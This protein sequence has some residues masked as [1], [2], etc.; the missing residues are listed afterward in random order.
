VHQHCPDPADIWWIILVLWRVQFRIHAMKSFRERLVNH[1]RLIGTLLN[2]PLPAIAEICAEAG[3][4]WLFLDMEHGALDLHDVERITQAVDH[5]CPCVV[6][7]PGND[8]AWIGK[9]LDFGV[10]GIIVPQVN[11]AEQAAHAVFAA[12]YPPQGGRGVGVGRASRYGAQLTSYLQTA[13]DETA[14]I[15]QIE[16]RD[17]VENVE[18]IASVAGV[19]ALMIGPLDLSGSFG[20]PAQIDAQEVQAA[21]RRV[22]EFGSQRQIPL[23]LFCPDAERAQRALD[24]G[25]TLVPVATDNLIFLRAASAMVESIKNG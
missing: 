7:V 12:K 22:R 4:D 2:F 6:R 15:V 21:I 8:R 24:E 11:T 19:D 18:A 10:A 23:S 3:F 25:Y 20:K 1:E 17:A 5:R 9:V 13:N 14:V 16:H